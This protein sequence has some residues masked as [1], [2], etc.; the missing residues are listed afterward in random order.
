MNR[1]MNEIK[2]GMVVQFRNGLYHVGIGVGVLVAIA[3]S[4]LI[5]ANILSLTMVG[6]MLLIIGGSTLLY[7]AA[8]L[9]V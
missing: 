6:I 7:V 8:I 1:L 5:N 4:Q 9:S 2:T 3:V